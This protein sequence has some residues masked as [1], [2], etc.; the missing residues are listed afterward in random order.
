MND[1]IKNTATKEQEM[2]AEN[3]IKMSELEESKKESANL[4]IEVYDLRKNG[5]SSGQ[6]HQEKSLGQGNL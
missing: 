6:Q 5:N 1:L 4:K 3:E 2:S